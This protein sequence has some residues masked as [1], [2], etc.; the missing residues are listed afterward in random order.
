MKRLRALFSLLII[1]NLCACSLVGN[2]VASRFNLGLEPSELTIAPGGAAV[3]T[4]SINPV[5]GFE[6]DPGN[7][8]ITLNN[9]P[10]WLSAEP[11]TIPGN[12]R[13]LDLTLSV[14]ADAPLTGEAVSVTVV[15]TKPSSG[16]T[17]TL[18]LTVSASDAPESAN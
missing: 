3:I 14:A 11:L 18:E 1:I 5:T 8:V 10:D 9:P 6:L 4:V 7:A 12:V 13:E 15:A 17:A 2:A 16:D